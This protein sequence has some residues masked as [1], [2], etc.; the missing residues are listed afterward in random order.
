[1]D[2]FKS[3]LNGMFGLNPETYPEDAPPDG[4]H[5]VHVVQP[6]RNLPKGSWRQHMVPYLTHI[7]VGF[8]AAFGMVVGPALEGPILATPFVMLVV[9][10][11]VRQTVE[12]MRRRDTP[13]RDLQHYMMGYMV[14]LVAG[15]L[16]LLG[17]D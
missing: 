1:M 16:S 13:G 10:I 11:C 17:I 14:G 2:K 3:A 9:F 7:F 6:R 15:A 8:A 4:A 5:V 12:F